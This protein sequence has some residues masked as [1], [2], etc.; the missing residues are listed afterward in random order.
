MSRQVERG[1][2]PTAPKR[3]VEE[4]LAPRRRQG[5]APKHAFLLAAV[6]LEMIP[7]FFV[8]ITAFKTLDDY[9]LSKIGPPRSLY[10]GNFV[11]ALRD[12]QFFVWLG[13]SVVLAVGAVLLSTTVSALAAFAFARMRFR[14]SGWLLSV[15]TALMVIPPV[16]MVVPLFLMLARFDLISTYPG[17]ILVYAGLVTPFSVYFLTNFFRGIPHEIVEAAL[18]DGSSSFGILTRILLP[19]SGPALMTLVI[20][21]SLWVWNDLLIALVLLP[22]DEMRPLMV[23]ITIFG[24]RYSS[25]VPV[26]MAGMLLASLPML[27]LYLFGQ[28]YFIRGIVAGA[29]KG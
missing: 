23:G 15:I 1:S 9:S 20:V 26:A 19:L 5:A 14:G 28:R 4:P 2:A 29:V 3:P 13:N 7:L 25:D 16:V 21:N 17:A 11:T 27:L 22:E 12:G 8:L 24:S 10:L 6:I 18:I